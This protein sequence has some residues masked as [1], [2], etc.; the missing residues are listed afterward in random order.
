MRRYVEAREPGIRHLLEILLAEW[1]YSPACLRRGVMCTLQYHELNHLL[2][3]TKTIP[4]TIT[5]SITPSFSN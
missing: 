5:S 3:F 1:A 4:E 2:T